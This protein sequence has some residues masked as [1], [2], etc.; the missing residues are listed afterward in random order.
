MKKKLVK[1]TTKEVVRVVE[2]EIELPAYFCS[3]KFMPSQNMDGGYFSP[4]TK[5]T[6]PDKKSPMITSNGDGC[7]V[8]Y[9]RC[10]ASNLQVVQD[11]IQ[12]PESEW[13]AA[14]TLLKA[15]IDGKEVQGE[16]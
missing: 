13:I 3:G 7:G 15:D 9:G 11:W 12:V 2:K 1:F 6:D 14:M 10:F 5:I 4:I 16:Q 8:A